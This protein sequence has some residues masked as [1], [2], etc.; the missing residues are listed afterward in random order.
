MQRFL[1]IHFWPS[2]CGVRGIDHGWGW[3][4]SPKLNKP[5]LFLLFPPPPTL[6]QDLL[7]GV[8][9]AL[10]CAAIFEELKAL[11]A[12]CPT[13]N[14]LLLNIKLKNIVLIEILAPIQCY[15]CLNDA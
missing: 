11:L 13:F 2:W 10:Q 3:K 15:L 9:S 14:I 7:C 5:D 8:L 12:L 6:I 4:G 1:I